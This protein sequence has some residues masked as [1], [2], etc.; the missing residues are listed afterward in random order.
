EGYKK[1]LS[2][3]LGNPE[4][5][6]ELFTAEEVAK[7]N[8]I[9]ILPNIEF[10]LNKIVQVNKASKDGKTKTEAGRINFHVIF[11]N[12]LSVKLIEESFLH[13]LDFVYESDPNESDKKRKLK[14][15]N[16]SQLGKRLKEEQQ[17]ILGSDLQVGMTNAV[18]DDGA[19]MDILTNNKDF[20]D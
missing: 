18:V 14:V 1:I 17:D 6:N 19:I 10:R 13:D 5:L 4:K 16:L 7:I 11:S 8:S 15:P 12:E 2:D 9:L 3:Y 20:K